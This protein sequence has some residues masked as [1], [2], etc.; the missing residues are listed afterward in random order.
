[1][2]R[3]KIIYRQKPVVE[4]VSLTSNARKTRGYF[5]QEL[6][7]RNGFPFPIPVIK[8]FLIPGI[9]PAY[10]KIIATGSTSDLPLLGSD[11]YHLHS[12]FRLRIKL[13]RILNSLVLWEG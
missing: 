3:T 5:C 7:T 6:K 1:M 12:F 9:G 13:N 10:D 4:S 8:N 11:I 2:Q